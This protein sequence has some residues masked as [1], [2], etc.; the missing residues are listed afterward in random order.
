MNHFKKKKKKKQENVPNA[1]TEYLPVN[2]KIYHK[3]YPD[4]EQKNYVTK[5]NS[6]SCLL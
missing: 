1:H 6:L 3:A 5:V 4:S 2:S